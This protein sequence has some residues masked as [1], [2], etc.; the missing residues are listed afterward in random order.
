MNLIAR[1]LFAM[2]MLMLVA[3][4]VFGFIVTFDNN[5]AYTMNGPSAKWMW[6]GIDAFAAI[7]SLIT[8][9]RLLWPQRMK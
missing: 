6:R 9:I 1:T 2:L 3:F 7:I 4:C 8:A 5:P